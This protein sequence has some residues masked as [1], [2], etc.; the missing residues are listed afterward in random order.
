[1]LEI[2]LR[3][4]A[5]E[6]VGAINNLAHSMGNLS[7]TGNC[8]G[9]LIG[10]AVEKHVE[11]LEEQ[12]APVET[13]KPAKAVKKEEVPK[14]ETVSMETVRARLGELGREGK[15]AAVKELIAEFGVAKL[16]DVPADRL[17]ELLERSNRL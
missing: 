13:K 7:A 8:V 15:T 12:E 11:T 2:K 14:V 1:M 10:Q 5:P 4:D 16:A 9:E 6:L 17:G 3:I